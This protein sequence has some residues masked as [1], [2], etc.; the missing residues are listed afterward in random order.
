MTALWLIWLATAFCVVTNHFYVQPSRRL[1]AARAGRDYEPGALSFGL[2]TAFPVVTLLVLARTFVIDVYHVPTESMEPGIEKGTR[3]F[4][5]KLAFGVKSPLSRD[6]IFAGD[7]PES[8]DV[9]VFQYPREPRTVFVK[10]VLGVPG[11]QI[12]VR[13]D[14]V[15]LNRFPVFPQSED[16][17][18]H[19]EVSLGEHIFTVYIDP[20]TESPYSL[21][22]EVPEGHFFVL[23]DNINHSKDSREWGLVSDRHL[24]GKIL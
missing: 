5:N 1:T 17:I 7:R 20:D 12:S 4:V 24:L 15:F 14:D 18:G 6:T 8:G 11:D 23:G 16:S 13:G 22:L 2:M 9:I 21:D 10:R 19:L 3:I